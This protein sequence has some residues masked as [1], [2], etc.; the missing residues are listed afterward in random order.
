MADLAPMEEVQ[1]QQWIRGLPWWSEFKDQ[2]GE[3]PDLN[4]DYDYRAAWKNG[5]EPQRYEY[6]GGKYHWPSAAPSGAMLKAFDHPTAWMEDYMNAT[7]TDPN[8]QNQPPL[9]D[10]SRSWLMERMWQRYGGQR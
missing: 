4:G 8:A 2:Y 5:I 10:G 9:D 7:G 3:E 6:D 1:F